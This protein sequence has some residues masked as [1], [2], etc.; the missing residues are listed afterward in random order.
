MPGKK[1]VSAKR[2]TGTPASRGPGAAGKADGDAAFRAW[3]KGVPDR[4]RTLVERLHAIIADELPG[5]R[6][7]IKWSMPMYGLPGR[8]WIVHVAPF[9]GYVAVGFFAGAQLEPPPPFGESGTMRRVRIAD[10]SGLDERRVRSW[11]Q[12]AAKLP[13]WGKVPA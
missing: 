3:L 1:A 4:H 5:A 8:G 10:A 11:L 2:A 7:T 6:C 9:K 13:G 12:Q